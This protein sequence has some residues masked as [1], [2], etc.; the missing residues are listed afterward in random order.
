MRIAI[1]GSTG[2]IG[3]QL[4]ATLTGQGHSVT[5]LVRSP[6]GAGGGAVVWNPDGSTI[7]KAALE[8]HDGVVHLAARNIA[9]ERWTLEVKAQ[10]KETRVSGTRLLC[11]ALSELSNPPKV[12]VSASAV[13]FYGN[14][15]DE[16]LTEGSALGTGFLAET[17]AEWESA[18]EAAA[19]KGIPVAK[20]RIGVV[21]SPKGGALAKMLPPFRLGLG[22]PIGSGRQYMSWISLD[23]I[24]GAII[25]V[26]SK[27]GL[28]GPVNG[29]A[30]H[31]VTN[32]EFARILGKVLGR[33]A[34][35]P[36]PAFAAR[37]A[38]GEM[39]D[40]LL[41]ASTRVEPVKLASSGYQFVHPDL[42]TALRALLSK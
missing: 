34:I 25:H 33:P 38:F 39:A 4:A 27:D 16:V 11:R 14:R 17:C 18:T 42:E 8:G 2:L 19:A 26:L 20:M 24:V 23:D 5:R 36:M 7:D 22:G 30:P 41:L 31:P 9:S 1:S 12:L 6:Q 13:G 21:M 40:E 10:I 35:F 29:V 15:G 37:F 28:S 32:A 3:S